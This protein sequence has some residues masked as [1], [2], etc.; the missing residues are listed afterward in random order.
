MSRKGASYAE[1]DDYD[2]SFYDDG[3]D[4]S[5]YDEPA[6]QPKKVRLMRMRHIEEAPRCCAAQHTYW[7]AL[8]VLQ[9]IGCCGEMVCCTMQDSAV[10]VW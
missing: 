7:G 10:G 5:E 2:D 6:V 8:T 4:Y 1:D 3:E 9:L